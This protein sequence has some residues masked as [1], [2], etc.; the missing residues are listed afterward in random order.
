MWG[1]LAPTPLGSAVRSTPAD[2]PYGHVG[3]CTYAEGI[4]H[5]GLNAYASFSVAERVLSAVRDDI[6]PR[7]A[8]TCLLSAVSYSK[9][10]WTQ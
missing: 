1:L 4:F 5:L 7:V 9:S 6:A 2:A 8:R 3:K 10:T